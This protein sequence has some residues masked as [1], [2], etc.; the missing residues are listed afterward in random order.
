MSR[1]GELRTSISVTT[2]LEANC[3]MTH[4]NASAG[5]KI[6]GLFNQKSSMV[7]QN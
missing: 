7:S 1:S 4:S 5:R 2:A 6:V 3:H